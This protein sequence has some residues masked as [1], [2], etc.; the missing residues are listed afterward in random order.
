MSALYLECTLLS[1]QKTAQRSGTIS[2]NPGSTS[3]K[4][5]E[6]LFVTFLLA[7]MIVSVE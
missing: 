5:Y 3:Y 6:R 1:V 2:G 7:G 4:R